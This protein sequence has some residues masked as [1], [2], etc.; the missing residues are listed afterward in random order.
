MNGCTQILSVMHI[1]VRTRDF[2]VKCPS[3]F[4]A[5]Q[6]CNE[7]SFSSPIFQSGKLWIH[8][9]ASVRNLALF[10]KKMTFRF[11]AEQG[12]ILTPVVILFTLL[13]GTLLELETTL[14]LG[15]AVLSGAHKSA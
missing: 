2:A 6:R 11:Y 5:F 10:R 3:S 13:S 12:L 7:V 15:L 9:S 4:S 1:S 14:L 8:T